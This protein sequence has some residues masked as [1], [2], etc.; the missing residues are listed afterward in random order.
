MNSPRRIT[1]LILDLD[2]TLYKPETGIWNMIGVRISK[3]M[4]THLPEL[5]PQEMK[6]LR[7]RLLKQYGTTLRGLHLEKNIDVHAYL[8]EV[9]DFDLS[10]LLKPDPEL[11]KALALCPQKKFI[12]TNASRKHAENVL[13]CMGLADL[14][15][16]ITDVLDVYPY[17]KPMPEAFQIMM[18]RLGITDTQECLYAD[19]N[20]A[21]LETAQALGFLPLYVGHK[22][23]HRFAAISEISALMNLPELGCGQASL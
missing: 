16:G 6:A 3:F 9:H 15:A 7:E 11:R 22:K 19:D 23:G 1:T 2:D 10:K 18:R 13:S 4:E 8:E 12:F 17:C 5:N 14:F 20:L 21:N